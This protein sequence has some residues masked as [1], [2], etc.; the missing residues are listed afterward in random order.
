MT[1]IKAGNFD[2]AF[3]IDQICR[4]V[5]FLF[6]F[7]QQA[8][9][10]ID[11]HADTHY[12]DHPAGRIPDPAVYK[13]SDLI[14]RT[15]NFII[16]DIKAVFFAALQKIIIPDVFILAPDKIA[17]QTVE[18]IIIIGGRR[19]QEHRIIGIFIFIGIQILPDRFL[20]TGLL[21]TAALFL[22]QLDQQTVMRHRLRDIHRLGQHRRQTVINTF[23][24]QRGDLFDLHQ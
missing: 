4:N 18:I 24:G 16:I 22:Q 20:V 1:V 17:V 3:F 14:G 2:L 19:N 15:S 12:T 13:Q 8:F 9:D 11:I 23:R 7:L 5:V 6:I 21:I 10:I